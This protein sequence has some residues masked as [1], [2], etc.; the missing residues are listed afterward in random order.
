MSELRAIF[1]TCRKYRYSLVR[2]VPVTFSF[3]DRKWIGPQVQFIGLNPSTA[4]E[5][6]DDPT[7]RRCVGF[8]SSFGFTR[9][10]MTNLFAFRETSPR[11]MMVEPDPVG[12]DNDKWLCDIA[13]QSGLIICAW[14]TSGIHHNRAAVVKD[15]LRGRGYKLHCLRK[16][17]CGEPSHPLYL[18]KELEPIE[19]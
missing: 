15:M 17:D 11:K 9:L 18:P 13:A 3:T 5:V 2:L 12:P 19:L 8:A 16:T 6:K 10:C 7:I 4:D 1:S 14:G